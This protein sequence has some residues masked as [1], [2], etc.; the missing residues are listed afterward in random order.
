MWH[1]A[2]LEEASCRKLPKTFVRPKV[3]ISYSWTSLDHQRW[4]L[5]VA[6]RLTEANVHAL[7]D[8]WDLQPGADSI[9]FMERMVNDPS[10]QKVLI[11]ADEKYVAKAND[12]EGG[13]G[14]ETQIISPELYSQTDAGKFVLVVCERDEKGRPY[15]PTYYKSKIYIDLSDEGRYAEEFE[16]LLRWIYDKPAEVRPAFGA[17]PSFL[18]ENSATD[19][20][21]AMYARRAMEAMRSGKPQALGSFIEYLDVLARHLERLRITRESGKEF[22]EQVVESFVSFKPFRD[23][24]LEVLRV[25]MTHSQDLEMGRVLHRF[26]EQIYN[27]NERPYDYIGSYRSTDFDNFRLVCRELFLLTNSLALKLQRLDVVHTLLEQDYYITVADGRQTMY[28]F[29]VMA[30][31]VES[32]DHRRRRLSSDRANLIADMLLNRA[33]GS[34]VTRDDVLQADFVLHLRSRLTGQRHWHPA[35]HVFAGGIHRAFE[36]FARSSSRAFFAKLA[37]ILGVDDVERLKVFVEQMGQY[38]QGFNSGDAKLLT[39]FDELCTRA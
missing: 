33:N 39:G 17:T 9:H 12:R 31:E 8:I 20:G 23:E 1:L 24:F 5:D 32:M 38:G 37:P 13:V 36:V 4:V 26:F 11:L 34:F 30:R 7:L 18:Q 10:V 15:L 35:T 22:D 16:K 14:T 19:L 25:V 21:T 6:K 29:G 2:F 27:Y 3:F 28:S